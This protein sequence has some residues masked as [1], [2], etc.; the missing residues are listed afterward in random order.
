MAA[1]Y[2][3]KTR[4]PLDPEGELVDAIFPADLTLKWYKKAPVRYWNL[5]AAKFV[6][7]NVQRIFRGI[8]EFNAGGWCYTA[9]PDDWYIRVDVVAPF[10]K[11]KVFAV[12][13]NPRMRVFECRAEYIADDDDMCPKGWRDRY[14]GLIWKGIS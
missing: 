4:N 3:C 9:R 12:Y 2:V 13:V 8:R 10:P 14:G 5:I 1:D 7:D 6:L 11:D